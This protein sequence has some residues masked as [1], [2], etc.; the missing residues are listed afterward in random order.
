MKRLTGI[1]GIFFRSSD[2]ERLPARY[3]QRLGLSWAVRQ[4]R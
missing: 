2:P 4:A 1:G 3:A